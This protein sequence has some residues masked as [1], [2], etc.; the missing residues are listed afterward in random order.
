MFDNRKTKAVE[1]KLQVV[2]EKHPGHYRNHNC[3]ICYILSNVYRASAY[4]LEQ[5]FFQTPIGGFKPPADLWHPKPQTPVSPSLACTPSHSITP[6]SWKSCI[7]KA[8]Y[9]HVTLERGT[10]V[11]HNSMRSQFAC[12][13]RLKLQQSIQ[14]ILIDILR[15][16]LVIF[17]IHAGAILER[18][19]NKLLLYT[20]DW[21]F[22]DTVLQQ[23]VKVNELMWWRPPI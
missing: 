17:T 9:V 18:T 16:M 13:S 2:G 5:W 23:N 19:S 10:A 12:S 1:A 7:R 14:R 21:C 6:P 4:L 22:L 11:L 15:Y 20:A 8:L 3:L